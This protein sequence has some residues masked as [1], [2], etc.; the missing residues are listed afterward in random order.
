MA[1]LQDYPP[2]ENC[3]TQNSERKNG[4]ENNNNEDEKQ[5]RMRRELMT[6]LSL[7][8]TTEGK[9]KVFNLYKIGSK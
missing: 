3:N 1:D 7:L 2:R 4:D 6:S 8:N 9:L 5:G